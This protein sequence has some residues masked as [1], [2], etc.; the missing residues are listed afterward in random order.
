MLIDVALERELRNHLRPDVVMTFK[1]V[2]ITV[3][4]IKTYDLP[5]KPRKA[6]D[7]RAPHILETVEAEALPASVLR[8]LLRAEVEALLP[9]NALRVA[10]VA[11]ESERSY[12]VDLAKA[13]QRS[14]S[15]RSE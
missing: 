4:Q 1:R 14:E 12:L 10:R 13:V 3:D 7:R 9:A 2:G 8:R 5:G 11:E 6:G 15:D